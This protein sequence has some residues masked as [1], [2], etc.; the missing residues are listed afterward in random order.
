VVAR[1]SIRQSTAQ[2]DLEED[3]DNRF[4]RCLAAME[5]FGLS[6]ST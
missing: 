5:A 3:F 2:A 1:S 6:H 4:Q